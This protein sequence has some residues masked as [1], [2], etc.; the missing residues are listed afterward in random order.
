MTKRKDSIYN[1]AI[2]FNNQPDNPDEMYYIKDNGGNKEDDNTRHKND[3]GQAISSQTKKSD[4]DINQKKITYYDGI[5]TQ[6]YMQNDKI[7]NK[8]QTPRSRKH[9]NHNNVIL[10]DVSHHEKRNQI[11]QQ[12]VG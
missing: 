11:N 2:T 5:L 1:I 12:L 8:T 10:P 7:K 9:N 6:Q 4:M 3:K